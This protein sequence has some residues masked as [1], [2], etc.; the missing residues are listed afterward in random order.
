MYREHNVAPWFKDC[1]GGVGCGLCF[2]WHYRKS[3]SFRR[4]R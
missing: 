4:N 1:F 2:N 3:A